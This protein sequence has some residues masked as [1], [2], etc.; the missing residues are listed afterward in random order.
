MV[1]M[2]QRHMDP[3]LISSSNIDEYATLALTIEGNFHNSLSYVSE[4]KSVVALF[5]AKGG[6]QLTMLS[7]VFYSL[8]I[9]SSFLLLSLEIM[10]IIISGPGFVLDKFTVF[11]F[12][13]VQPISI[14]FG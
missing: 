7:V 6:E 11:P 5:Q 8:Q 4:L 10:I 3:F 9:C 2:A 1:P 12:E 14:I 13:F